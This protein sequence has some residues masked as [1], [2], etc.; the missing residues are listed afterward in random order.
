MFT[1]QAYRDTVPSNW[2]AP[3]LDKLHALAAKVLGI[4]T[5][6]PNAVIEEF[7][8]ETT[9]G[10]VDWTWADA[11]YEALNSAAQ[12][13]DGL[14]VFLFENRL[15]VAYYVDDPMIAFFRKPL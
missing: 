1:K 3:E 15:T 7:C 4:D 9:E 10:Q 6:D 2:S 11:L 12:S 8:V 14:A 5:S 13:G